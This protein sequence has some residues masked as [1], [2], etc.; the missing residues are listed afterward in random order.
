MIGDKLAENVIAQL[1]VKPYNGDG[2]FLK[3]LMIS[4]KLI[5]FIRDNFL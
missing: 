3:N 1:K 5:V 2:I 4:L